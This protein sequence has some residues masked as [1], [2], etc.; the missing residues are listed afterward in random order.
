MLGWAMALV[1]LEVG[2]VVWTV[3]VVSGLECMSANCSA[4]SFF[5]GCNIHDPRLVEGDS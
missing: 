4:L 3:N 5:R 2:G 1:V